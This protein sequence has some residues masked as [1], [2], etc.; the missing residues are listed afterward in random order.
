ME[1]KNKRD[2]LRE[3]QAENRKVMETKRKEE[4]DE[5]KKQQTEEKKVREK[6]S[7]SNAS[8]FWHHISPLKRRGASQTDPEQAPAPPIQPVPQVPPLQPVPSVQ[9]VPPVP[10]PLPT[11]DA[12][13]SENN[14]N[15]G[16]PTAFRG[17]D[18]TSRT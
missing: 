1:K 16:A 15:D 7:G 11:V 2:E 13:S 12:R 4:R 5:S 6:K 8:A 10:L 3:Q 17:K 9:L 14:A 18:D